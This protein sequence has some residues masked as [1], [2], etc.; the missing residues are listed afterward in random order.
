MV[1]DVRAHRA[2]HPQFHDPL[3]GPQPPGYRGAL[4]PDQDQQCGAHNRGD[5][6]ENRNRQAACASRNR[7][8][9]GEHKSGR[10]HVEE[11]FAMDGHLDL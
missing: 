9:G 3:P 5:H 2:E 6:D 10:Q 4:A 8:H 1:P 11:G 7:Q